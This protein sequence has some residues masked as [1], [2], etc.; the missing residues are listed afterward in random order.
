MTDTTSAAPPPAGRREWVGLA[1][2]ALPTL[3][4]ALD[5]GALFLALPHLS[6]DLHASATQ[7]LWIT[8]IYGFMLAGFLIT[9]GT[10]G[11]RVGRRRLLL[12][13]A[14]GFTAA[15]VLTA[16]STSPAMLILARGLLG[17]AGATLG[18]STLAL[19]S[20][21]F[22]QPRQMGIAIS[23]W[24][25]CQFGGAALGPVIGGFMLEH[26]WWGSVF[27]LGVPFMVLLMI[28]G[29]LF[30]PE[31]RDENAAR[32]DLV[33]VLMS[34]CAIL[35]AIY[36]VKQLAAGDSGT[37][38]VPSAAIAVGL[39]FGILFVRRQLSVEHPLVDLSLFR[40]RA[41]S[42]ALSA[43]ML[44]CATFAGASFMSSQYVQSVLGLTPAQAG[45]WQAPAGA[46]IAA[47]VLLAPVL[48]RRFQAATVIRAGLLV[49]L[50][51]LLLM[52]LLTS[53]SGPVL[54]SVGV[55]A[56]AIGVGPLFAL[57]TGLI[58]GSAPPEKAGSAAS[59]SET[60]NVFGST[61]GL[62]ILGSV[63]AA[64]YHGRIAEHS[65]DPTVRQTVA[66]AV[67]A[68][69]AMP[70]ARQSAA[71]LQHARVAFTDGMN[72]VAAIGA[73]V[74]AVLLV[75][76]TLALRSGPAVDEAGSSHEDLAPD[77]SALER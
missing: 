35:P 65:T 40:T 1:C 39:A 50:L 71:L 15:S 63:G 33:S 72:T 2:L 47:G 17:V 30:L 73:V 46:G 38:Y 18:P 57:G 64:V 54:V 76:T 41:F 74:I 69:H 24:A 9:M 44:A 68:A 20:N 16:F 48:V 4:V 29:P 53:T 25:G 58:L 21:M 49:S 59:M 23:L 13:G 26:F 67:A 22:R 61:M 27:L 19:I 36:G 56:V 37:L 11:D 10:L 8:D 28:L 14:A 77:M 31:Y 75:L 6:T 5:I 7:Q 12:I 55:G 34:L 45:A 60:S 62:A 66:D 43:M 51:G 52:T 42:S 32:L 3:L 70:D